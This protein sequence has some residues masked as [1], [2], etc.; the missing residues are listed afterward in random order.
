MVQR[1]DIKVIEGSL[2]VSELLDE[3]R[4]YPGLATKYLLHQVEAAVSGL[5]PHGFDSAKGADVS[6]MGGGTGARD[7][8]P[9]APQHRH[10]CCFATVW[11][12][13]RCVC[14]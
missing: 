14:A 10:C 11:L 9:T 3:S 1:R 7:H 2:T 8:T 13:A 4:S 5:P 12:R 6:V